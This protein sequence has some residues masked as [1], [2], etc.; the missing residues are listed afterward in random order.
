MVHEGVHDSLEGERGRTGEREGKFDPLVTGWDWGTAVL[1]WYSDGPVC[2]ESGV[3]SF[4]G[5]GGNGNECW[6]AAVVV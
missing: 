2:T 1:T 6:P 3:E 4:G 5:V